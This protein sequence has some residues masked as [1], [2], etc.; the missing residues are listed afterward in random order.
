M[1]DTLQ[2][3]QSSPCHRLCCQCLFSW[4]Q[5]Y[6]CHQGAPCFSLVSPR[7]LQYETVLNEELESPPHR[8]SLPR[9]P[10]RVLARK[11]LGWQLFPPHRGRGPGQSCVCSPAKNVRHNEIP[12]TRLSVHNINSLCSCHLNHQTD[13]CHANHIIEQGAQVFVNHCQACSSVGREASWS[14]SPSPPCGGGRG[15]S[16]LELPN[17]GAWAWLAVEL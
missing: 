15:H 12:V 5:S 13:R 3:P 9:L 16:L 11:G 1:I 6:W 17:G 4:Q 7:K 2:I 10:R 8:P 14:A